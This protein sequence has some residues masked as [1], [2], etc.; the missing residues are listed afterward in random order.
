[1]LMVDTDVQFKPSDITALL[2]AEKPIISGVTTSMDSDGT[3]WPVLMEYDKAND[4]FQRIPFKKLLGDKPIR[5]GACGCSFVL[6]ERQ[7]LEKLGVG[8]LWPYAEMVSENGMP[9]GEDITFC[10]RA[11]EKGFYTWAHPKILV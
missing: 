1:M 10:V 11:R 2:E 7:V 9:R 3:V 6:I 5:I 4:R 8:P